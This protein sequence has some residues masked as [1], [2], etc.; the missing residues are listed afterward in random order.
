MPFI[1]SDS[2]QFLLDAEPYLAACLSTLSQVSILGARRLTDIKIIL[3]NLHS[4]SLTIVLISQGSH[5]VNYIN[6]QSG[7]LSPHKAF[8]K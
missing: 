4:M 1:E 2:N 6:K 5:I 3:D 8:E 7:H